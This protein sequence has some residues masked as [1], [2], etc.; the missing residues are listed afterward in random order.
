M[1]YSGCLPC[2][3]GLS[4]DA[5][6]VRPRAVAG[7]DCRCPDAPAARRH[8]FNIGL[9]A[10]KALFHHDILKHNTLCEW[11]C[12]PDSSRQRQRDANPARKRRSSRKARGSRILRVKMTP[13][14][15]LVDVHCYFFHSTV[16]FFA[17]CAADD[18]EHGTGM[19]TALIQLPRRPVG[20]VAT[21]PTRYK[22]RRREASFRP[23]SNAVTQSR[24]N[25]VMP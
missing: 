17:R 18:A 7:R 20:G 2:R 14:P 6:V 21:S 25:A 13:R 11:S 16:K 5:A 1:R 12:H 9:H 22:V 4:H 3:A 15:I 19:A 23:R 24:G 8:K 10:I